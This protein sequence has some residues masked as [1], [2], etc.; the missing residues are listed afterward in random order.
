MNQIKK[1]ILGIGLILSGFATASAQV[2]IYSGKNYTGKSQTFTNA[3]E[4][5]VA[6]HLSGTIGSIKVGPGWKA[7][8]IGSWSDDPPT[9]EVTKDIADLA[10][11]N[12]PTTVFITIEGSTIAKAPTPRASAATNNSLQSGQKL[13]TGQML[14][15]ANGKFM[16]KMQED[17]NLCIYHYKN[18]VQG[19][20][21]WGSMVHG[22]KGA[23]LIL[24]DDGNLVVYDGQNQAKW[25]SKTHPHFDRKFATPSNKPVRLV[26]GDDGTLKLFTRAGAE[27][28]KA[29]F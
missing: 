27:V 25:S 6:S 26:L 16:L 19:A 7:R 11:A 12:F 28:W 22:F 9:M 18:G 23:Y 1:S 10:K 14:V 21:S 3:V 17:G 24:Q 13:S 29:A 2:T 20:F 15:A 5:D 8:L 4:T